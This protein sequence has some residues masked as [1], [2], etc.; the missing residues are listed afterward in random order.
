MSA[1]RATPA[2]RVV[3]KGVV[4]ELRPAEGPPQLPF[5]L[6]P[7]D[8]KPL[9][10]LERSLDADPVW[11]VLCTTSDHPDYVATLRLYRR[12]WYASAR[13]GQ[14][15]ATL[16]AVSALATERGHEAGLPAAPSPAP[17]RYPQQNRSARS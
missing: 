4:V 1:R 11:R 9:L 8:P 6:G 15:L 2:R 5:E 12:R 7:D 13:L 3:G 16:D 14:L 10:D 17:T